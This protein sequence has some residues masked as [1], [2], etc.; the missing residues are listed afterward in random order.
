MAPRI[1]NPEWTE[2]HSVA[3]RD[4]APDVPAF[5]ECE[6]ALLWRHIEGAV[7]GP[8]AERAPRRTRWKAVA[9]GFAVAGIVGVAGA[10]TGGVLSAHT[11]K[12][13]VDAEDARLGGPGERLDPAAGDFASALDQV[14]EDIRF[15]SAQS[16]ERALSWEV[17]DQAGTVD[18]T[19]STGALRLWM[20]GHALCSWT[21]TWAAAQR[22]GDRATQQEAAGVILAARNWPAIT[23]TD[24]TMAGESEFA[25]LPELEQAVEVGDR[26][27]ARHA[28]RPNASCM[29]GLAP[30]LGMGEPQ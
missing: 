4:A 24:P 28:L 12:G 2:R 3:V 27:A 14:T 20:A 25:W 15:P 29:P 6:Q 5:P 1:G 9:A 16:R 21:N 10:A 11:G 17:E 19:V 13:P 22:A 7:T 18:T 8:A 26:S 30:E 23:D